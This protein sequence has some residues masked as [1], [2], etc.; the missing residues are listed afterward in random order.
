MGAVCINQLLGRKV[1]MVEKNRVVPV[2]LEHGVRY[3]VEDRLE[4]CYL[5]DEGS[6]APIVF[7]QPWNQKPHPFKTVRNW[8]EISDMIAW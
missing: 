2:L 5:L 7:E 8:H 6:V 4:T 3:F 1:I